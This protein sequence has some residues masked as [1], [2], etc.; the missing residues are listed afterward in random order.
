MTKLT[1]PSDKSRLVALLLAF[2][3]GMIG[4]HRFYVGKIVSGIF[5]ILTFG[6]FGLWAMIDI[7]VVASGEFRDSDGYKLTRWDC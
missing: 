3:F 1:E 5:M 7:I 6:G 2:F 4:V